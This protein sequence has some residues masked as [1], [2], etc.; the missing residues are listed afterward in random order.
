MAP[1]VVACLLYVA[2]PVVAATDENL[3]TLLDDSG[4][5][6]ASSFL[7]TGKTLNNLAYWKCQVSATS[8]NN[9]I[10]MRLAESGET[11]IQGR[12]GTWFARSDSQIEINLPDN[13]YLLDNIV[14]HRAVDQSDSFSATD[15]YG[16]L[17]D[18]DWNGDQR[19]VLRTFFDDGHESDIQKLITGSNLNSAKGTTDFNW[20]CTPI[21]SGSNPTFNTM[22]LYNNNTAVIDGF[23]TTW[24]SS[25][26]GDLF[27]YNESEFYA[28]TNIDFSLSD[29]TEI[30]LNINS[31]RSTCVI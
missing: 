6:P 8:Q 4:S 24:Y 3:V 30:G 29:S 20:N 22:T 14:T 1:K 5:L 7:Q 23:P 13:S 9:S 2:M 10:N 21:E 27:L 15:T 11:L 17:L 25:P 26:D 28:L 19:N 16:N 12:K 31:Q 18:C